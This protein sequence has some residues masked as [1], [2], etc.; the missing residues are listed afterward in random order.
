MKQLFQNFAFLIVAVMLTNNGHSQ[1]VHPANNTAFLQDE[2][3]SVYIEMN[4]VDLNYL[5][6]QDSL[7]SDNEYTARFIYSCSSFTDTLENVGFR[8]RGNTSR[9]AEKKSFKV[10][11]NTYVSGRKWKNLE[12]MNLNGE[13]NDV[14]I[15]RTQLSNMVLRKAGVV[16]SRTSYVK[17]YINTTYYG[18][19]IN[20]E[21][22]DDEFLQ[23]RFINDDQGNLYKCNYGANLTNLGTNSSAYESLYELKT[24]ES[25]ND[26][27]GLVNFIQVLNTSSAANFPCDIQEVFDVDFYLRTLA[28]EIL[29]G[30]WD[31]YSVNKN[32]YYLYQRPSDGKFVFI[33]YDLDNTWGIDWL[34]IEWTSKNI[35][36]FAEGNR[37][38][39]DRIMA[40][41][42]F[43][44]RFS[45]YMNE[46]VTSFY[47]NDTLIP[48]I[49]AIQ[50]MIT[51][52]AYA[53]DYKGYDYG[54]TDQDFS[55]AITT[56]WGDHITKSLAN[57]LFLR[58]QSILNQLVLGNTTNPCQLSLDELSETF[59]V[60][61]K[62]FNFLG[63]EVPITT[64]Q[65]PILV[66]DQYGH[67]KHIFTL[68]E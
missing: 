51:P 67:V 46:Y 49:S 35:Y 5:Y 61:V 36:D 7:F 39:Y 11:F 62:A 54:F 2:V 48:E 33:E 57:F 29:I 25:T 64:T 21:H 24:N 58:R 3:A 47:T 52:A 4:P 1:L 8:L 38:L 65:Q 45:F 50:S 28:C 20:V 55:A 19:Y 68:A 41:P 9:S 15:L 66:M 37:P 63:Q 6:S 14:S 42:Y 30:Q 10:S 26:Y 40:V 18:L 59:G 43:K 22:I 13:H 53:D 16:S 34:G 12:K 17:L 32:N 56:A 23:H 27:S 31:G 60:P 44:D